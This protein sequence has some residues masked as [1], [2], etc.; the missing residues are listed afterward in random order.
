[1]K[2]ILREGFPCYKRRK[3]CMIKGAPSYMMM[4]IKGYLLLS[5][6]S[7]VALMEEDLASSMRA[8]RAATSSGDGGFSLYWMD[9]C[10]S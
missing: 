5:K 6:A 1:M 8:L 2:N 10:M 3:V 4:G 9:R 7:K